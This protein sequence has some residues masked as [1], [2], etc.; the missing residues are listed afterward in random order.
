MNKIYFFTVSCLVL[1]FS[2]LGFAQQKKLV[3]GGKEGW[4]NVQKMD[5]VV[6]GSGKYGWQSIELDTD[7]RRVDQYT[8]MLLDFEDGAVVDLAGNYRTVENEIICSD[9]AKMGKGAGKMQGKSGARFRGNGSSIFGSSG[10]SGSWTIEFWLKPSIAENGEKVFAWR[11]SRT[12]ANYPLYQMIEAGFF[13]NRLEWTFTNVFSGYLENGGQV[14]LEGT[15]TLIP[16]RWTHHSISFDSDIGLLEYKVDGSTEDLKYVTSNGRQRGGTV[17][18]MILGV[19]ADINICPNYIGFIDDFRIQRKV[20]NDQNVTR[21]DLYKKDGG[22][23]ETVPMLI[24]TGA[25]L[26]HISAVVT[27]PNET[28]VVLYVR[29]GD[30]YFDWTDSYPKWIPVENDSWIEG[31]TGMYFQVAADLLPDGGGAHTPK[32]SQV[33]LTYTEVPEPLPPWTVIAE[34]GDGQITLSWSFSVDDTTGGYYIF[35]GERPGEYISSDAV[36]GDSPLLVGNVNSY[37]L[38]GLK[39][40]K[41]YYFA[42]ASYSKIDGRI[43]GRLS[44]EVYARPMKR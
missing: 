20:L 37:T 4:S 17:N 25:T 2:S 23:F 44:K 30:N 1:F 28:Q 6:F 12:I 3:L 35:Y 36:N 18:T 9:G 39:N 31:V 21:Y 22:R 43:M 19:V 10:D 16:N 24:S 15:K 29:S 13:G 7:S 5:G 38:K 42:V 34:P 8:D 14:V 40:G 26:N 32:L 41:I 33:E 11:S 27:E